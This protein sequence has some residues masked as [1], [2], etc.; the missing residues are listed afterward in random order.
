MEGK[1]KRKIQHESLEIAKT[2]MN[3]QQLKV[4]G[5][6]LEPDLIKDVKME[7]LKRDMTIQ[8]YVKLALA[9]FKTKS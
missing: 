7:A 2:T 3:N 6:K 9:E 5:V 8:E 1:F 4:F